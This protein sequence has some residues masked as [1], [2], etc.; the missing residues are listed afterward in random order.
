MA[1]SEFL[2]PSLLEKIQNG[3][4]ILFLGAG[5]SIGSAGPQGEKPMSG[6]ALRDRLSDRFLGGKHKDKTLVRVADLAKHQNSLPDVQEYIHSLFHPLVPSSFHKL[7]PTFRWHAI[8]TTNYDL[9]VERAYE[10]VENRKQQ[11]RPIIRDGDNF[12]NVL[13]DS[14]ALPFLKLHGCVKTINDENLPLIL[15]SEEYAK[16]QKN[17]KRLFSH[18]ADWARERPVIFVGY[19]I[20]D[21]NIQQIL[22]DLTDMGIHRQTYVIVDP[23]LDPM[24]SSYWSS[25]RFIPVPLTF[26]SFLNRLNELIPEHRRVLASVRVGIEIS[27]SKWFS[28]A[29][30][31]SSHLVRY[32]NEELQH[33]HPSLNSAGVSPKAFYSGG[34][35]DW[36]VFSQSLDIKRR[37][38]DDLILGTVLV[39]G[40]LNQPFV[41]FVKGHAGAG[42]TVALKRFAWDAAKDFNAKILYLK[43]GGVLRT[44][45]IIELA[46]LCKEPIV[47]V[48][49]DVIK[50]LPDVNRLYRDTSAKGLG[51]R[52]VIGA[53]TNEWNQASADCEFPISDEHELKDLN[54]KEITDLLENLFRYKALGELERL[55]KESQIERFKLHADRQLMVALHEATTG[56]PFEEL[57]YDEYEHLTPPEAKILYL[58]ICTLHRLGVPV[59]AGL[60]SRISGV[61]FELFSRDFLR[62]LEHVIYTYFDA[63]CRDYVYRSRH[64]L[65]AE[66]VFKWAVP[67]PIE[68]AAQIIRIIRH[69]D[70]D[71][72][73]D[74]YAFGQLI[75]GRV[76]A[77]LFADKTLV[78]QVFDAALE[79][80]AAPEYIHHQYA[81]FELNHPG[82]SMRVAFDEIGRAADLAQGRDRSIEHTKAVVLRRLANDSEHPLERDKHRADA[83]LILK[84]LKNTAKQSHSYD[85]Y[86]RLLMDELRDHLSVDVGRVD[87]SNKDLISRSLSEAVRQIEECISIGLQKFPNDEHILNLDAD[88]ARLLEDEPRALSSLEFAVKANPARPFIAVRLANTYKRAG[89]VEDAVSILQA[90]LQANPSSKECHYALATVLI[91]W[92]EFKNRQDIYYHLKRSFTEGDTNFGAQFWYARYELLYGDKDIGSALFK[93]LSDARIPP[94]YKKQSRGQLSTTEGKPLTCSGYI[95]ALGASFGFASSAELRFDVFVHSSCFS[96]SDWE[97]LREGSRI[98]FGVTF[99]MRGAVAIRCAIAQ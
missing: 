32:L 82:G 48:V 90:C 30:T 62:P 71:Y 45:L 66:F 53:R 70:T 2:T 61:T 35:N 14:N 29:V 89:R 65:I 16:H 25:Y 28:S 86:G 59:R 13:K 23:G 19:D 81:V 24:L 43:E 5:A 52:I 51:V 40:K 3:D 18:F 7:I 10:L 93:R 27:V 64:P 47:V 80:G 56:K 15:A 77:E 76:L 42:K 46:E 17:R 9:I 8:V 34:C 67:D 57:A 78:R 22:F 41:I 97:E 26:E 72:E 44:H 58:D 75:R 79:S 37:L 68:R 85:T 84:R 12:S 69:M 31:P 33:V 88:L 49:D 74:N 54:E 87:E 6:L 94:S 21:P 55:S 63:S 11:L 60:V 1:D 83:K 99:T 50:H 98:T 95:K 39:E 20:A 36:A 92:D 38:S 91:D 73:S 4:C 96:Q